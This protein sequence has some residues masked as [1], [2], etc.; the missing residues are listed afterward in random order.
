MPQTLDQAV[1]NAYSDLY[2]AC[3]TPAFD[4]K[5]VSFVRKNIK[6]Q[7]YIYISTKVGQVPVQKYIGPDNSQTRKLIEQEK[8]HWHSTDSARTTRAR[9][10]NMVLAGGLSGPTAQ[11]GKIVRM[12]ERAG[13]FLSGGVLIGTPAFRVMG[14]LLGVAWRGQFATRDVDIAA[15][16]R[17]PVAV[18]QRAIDLQDVLQKSAMGFIEVPMLHP[19]HPATRYKMRDGEHRVELF[20]PEL[21]KSGDQPIKIPY[22]NAVAEPLR[23]LDY[24]I[25]E[26]QP[27]VIPFDIGV[28]VNVPDPARFAIHK[29]VVSQRRPAAFAAKAAK[30]I[31]QARQLLD[32]LLDIRPGSVSVAVEAARQTGAKFH[33]HYKKALTRLPTDLQLSL[34]EWTG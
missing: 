32:V 3:L 33:Q 31:D 1:Q 29:L 15:D 34:R 5:G 20:T 2:A 8:Q 16:F 14:A 25:A 10:V 4:G 26:T 22:L 23:F 27:A 7:R 18:E 24:L 21:G 11:E 17:L 19:K 13:V 28:L 9:L 30:D 6:G 12:L